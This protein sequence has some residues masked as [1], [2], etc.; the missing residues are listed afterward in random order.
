MQIHGLGKPGPAA[1]PA[2]G[3]AGKPAAS[4]QQTPAKADAVLLSEKA[5]DLAAQKAGKGAEEERTESL[6][7]KIKEGDAD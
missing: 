4:A 1:G 6:A 7:S 3:A 2:G 5:K